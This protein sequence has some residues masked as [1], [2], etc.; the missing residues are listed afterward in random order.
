MMYTDEDEMKEE[1]L[2]IGGELIRKMPEL[3][4]KTDLIWNGG[5]F[6]VLCTLLK[7]NATPTRNLFLFGKSSTMIC[8]N[9]E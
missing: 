4:V 5:N 7:A 6:Q 1:A 3:M 2:R 8:E 9:E